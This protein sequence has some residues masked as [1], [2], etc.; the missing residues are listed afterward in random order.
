MAS[1]LKMQNICNLIEKAAMFLIFLIAT[2]QIK[3][4]CGKQESEAGYTKHMNLHLNLF[5]F[6]G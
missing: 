6:I 4:E 1:I 2:I 5:E 3:L